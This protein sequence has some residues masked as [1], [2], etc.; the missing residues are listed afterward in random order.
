MLNFIDYYSQWSPLT[1]FIL[2]HPVCPFFFRLSMHRENVAQLKAFQQKMTQKI[3]A[4]LIISSLIV[5][6]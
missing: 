5:S 3:L 1:M 6:Q 2:R 4:K